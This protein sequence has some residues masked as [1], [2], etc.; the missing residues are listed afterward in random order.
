[1]LNV[2][3]QTHTFKNETKTAVEVFEFSVLIFCDAE[4]SFG[5]LFFTRQ[6]ERSSNTLSTARAKTFFATQPTIVSIT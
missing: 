4:V 1:M 5:D 3:Y 6:A 2:M